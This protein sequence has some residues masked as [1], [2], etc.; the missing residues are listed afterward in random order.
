MT[1]LDHPATRSDR[2]SST[3]GSPIKSD[4][5][6]ARFLAEQLIEFPEVQGPHLPLLPQSFVPRTMST[7]DAHLDFWFDSLGSL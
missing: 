6:L 2:D 5:D 7:P 4:A 3:G 1:N